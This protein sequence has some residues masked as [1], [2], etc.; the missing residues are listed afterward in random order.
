MYNLQEESEEL[1]NVSSLEDDISDYQPLEQMENLVRQSGG[2]KSF[3]HNLS[4]IAKMSKL[5]KEAQSKEIYII[6]I[7]ELELFVCFK[8]CSILS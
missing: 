8:F 2:V 6:H 1:S 4:M 5:Q 3:I 7:E